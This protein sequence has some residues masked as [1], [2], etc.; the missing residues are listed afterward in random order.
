MTYGR[1]LVDLIFAEF[2]IDR[3]HDHA[4]VLGGALDGDVVVLDIFD[5]EVR[6]AFE[7]IAETAAAGRRA[8]EHIAFADR[9]V[10]EDRAEPFLCIGSGALQ[11]QAVGH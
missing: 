1:G 7:R 8:R 11:R 6:L 3:K 5:D 9:H 4:V 2:R 10:R